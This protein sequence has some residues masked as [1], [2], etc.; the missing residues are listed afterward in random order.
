M[1]LFYKKDM[2]SGVN[3]DGPE[4]TVTPVLLTLGLL[5]SAAGVALDQNCDQ[6]DT[7]FGPAG[8]CDQCLRGWCG[9]KCSDVI[10]LQTLDL[11]DNVTVV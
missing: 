7:N 5:R 3:G 11:L 8:Q 6:C 9:E 1:I 2:S 4:T 10:V